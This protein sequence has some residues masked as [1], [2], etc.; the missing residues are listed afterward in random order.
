MSRFYALVI[1][2]SNVISW[3]YSHFQ[4]KKTI[5]DILIAGYT[6][7]NDKKNAFENTVTIWQCDFLF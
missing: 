1:N 5:L 7:E 4:G 3:R 6:Q 2:A